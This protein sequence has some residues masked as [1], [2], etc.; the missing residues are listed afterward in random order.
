MCNQL[1]K[2][3]SLVDIKNRASGV[4]ARATNEVVLR[5]P[6]KRREWPTQVL[7]HGIPEL[8]L[9]LDPRR[10]CKTE[11]TQFV[12]GHCH[13]LLVAA[14]LGHFRIPH[15]PRRG[16]L[17]FARVAFG[18]SVLVH[19][20]ADDFDAVVQTLRNGAHHTQNARLGVGGRGHVDGPDFVVRQVFE[21]VHCGWFLGLL[22][23]G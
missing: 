4:D 11:Q 1:L 18:D 9:E 19:V 20:D 12:A 5:R 22:V 8:R 16:I 10:T 17:D 13:E 21:V 3:L 6:I 23:C 7:E 15:D 2:K 14:I